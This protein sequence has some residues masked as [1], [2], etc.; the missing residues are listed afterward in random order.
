MGIDAPVREPVRFRVV[1][2]QENLARLDRRRDERSRR[3]RAAPRAN[4]DGNVIANVSGSPSLFAWSTNGLSAAGSAPTLPFHSALSVM[5]WPLRF[6]SHGITIGFFGEPSRP[7]VDASGMP[8]SMWV[9]WIEPEER[10]SRIAAQFAPFVTV[11]LMPY[12]LN[13][14]FSCAMTMGEQSVSAIMPKFRF[15][16]SGPS[17]ALAAVA[18]HARLPSADQSAAAPTPAAARVRNWRRLS[19][20]ATG[21][22]GDPAEV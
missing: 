13:R 7:I 9:A 19:E 16:V 22:V 4:L 2:R 12:F 8:M 14:P 11:E 1:H 5:A 21:L 20:A 15:G 17:P 18:A 10:L 6:I 3:D